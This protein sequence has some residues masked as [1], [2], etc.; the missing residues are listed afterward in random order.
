MMADPSFYSAKTKDFFTRDHLAPLI[1]KMFYGD[2]INLFSPRMI[3][4][5]DR[6]AAL[7]KSWELGYEHNATFNDNPNV[8]ASDYYSVY[9]PADS[10]WYPAWFINTEEVETG[11]QGWITNVDARALPLSRNR[12]ILRKVEGTIRFSTAVNFSTRFPVFS[13]GGA[14]DYQL[15][16]Y[17]YVDGGYIE[18]YGAQTMLEVLQ[19]LRND[20]IFRRYKPYVMIIQFGNDSRARPGTVTFANEFTEIVNGIYNTRSGR[21]VKAKL[22]LTTFVTDSL[23]GKL[24]DIPLDISNAKVPMNWILSDTSLRRL[25]QYCER[26]FKRNAAVKDILNVMKFK[27][28]KSQSPMIIQDSLKLNEP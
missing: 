2:M 13:P 22:D 10:V 24:V 25:D 7:E 26:L 17:H 5:F 8:F 3:P 20:S 16:R 15:Q 21:G 27:R 23:K 11:L 28:V 9:N 18:N 1:G 4:V 14:L 19:E 12:D 6:A